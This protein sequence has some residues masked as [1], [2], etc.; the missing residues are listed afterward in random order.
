MVRSSILAALVCLFAVSLANAAT[1]TL[2]YKVATKGAA[3]NAKVDLDGTIAAVENRLVV[4]G[5]EH[6]DVKPRGDRRIAVVL[7]DA[8]ATVLAR[9]KETLSQSGNLE[10]R[11]VADSRIPEHREVIKAA[12]AALARPDNDVRNSA[13]QLIG[14]WVKLDPRVKLA[15]T[16]IHRK[17][18]QGRKECLVVMDK[19]NVTGAYLTSA[20][21]GTSEEGNA[22]D[23]KLDKKG[24]KLLGE[25]TMHN[26][27]DPVSGIG[28]NLAIIIDNKLVSSAVIRSKI[29]DAGQITGNF[30]EAEVKNLVSIF[31]FGPLP[32]KLELVSEST[33]KSP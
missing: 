5:I 6:A 17:T 9:A 22:I 15:D 19:W 27:P 31:R 7:P 10:F 13:K 1:T 30:T 21:P 8:D 2:I 24:A 4:A 11:I 28:R 20:A 23:F 3:A 12:K 26:L 33:A 16:W 18:K 32:A 29:T 14:K 25:L